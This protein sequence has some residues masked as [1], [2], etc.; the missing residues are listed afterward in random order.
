MA[1]TTPA[2]ALYERNRKTFGMKQ[3]LSFKKWPL[4]V[5]ALG[6]VITVAFSQPNSGHQKQ[7]TTDTLP[8]KQK[9]VRDLDEALAEIDRSEIELQQALKEIDYEKMN[10]DIRD[11]MKNVEVDMA[12]AKEE[13]AKAMKEVDMQKISLEVQKAMKEIDWEQIKKDVDSSL[14]KIDTEKMKAEMEKAKVEMEKVRT[15]DF[16]RMQEDLAKIEPEVK[17]AMAEAKV[18]IE[19]A[20]KEITGYKNLVA[21]LE[22]DGLLKKGESYK[23]EYKSGELRVNGKTLSADA[24]RRYSEYLSNKKDFTLKKDDDGLNIHHD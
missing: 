2:V 17:K 13:V 23:I 10:A 11:A 22:K 9:K 19:K 24:T 6:M 3:L 5:L 21:A 12:K 7:S 20:R 14:A 16:K 4:L 8:T 15:I 1:A 18:E